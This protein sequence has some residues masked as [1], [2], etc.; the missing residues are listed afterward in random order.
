[1]PTNSTVMQMFI[2]A[3]IACRI[4]KSF[5]QTTQTLIGSL[6]QVLFDDGEHRVCIPKILRLAFHMKFSSQSF[7]LPRTIQ[8]HLGHAGHSGSC[9]FHFCTNLIAAS[10]SAN[11]SGVNM[12]VLPQNGHASVLSGKGLSIGHLK[13]FFPC[14]TFQGRPGLAAYFSVS[15]AQHVIPVRGHRYHGD[16]GKGLIGLDKLA[17][18]VSHVRCLHAHIVD[19]SLTDVKSYF[20]ELSI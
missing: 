9:A 10:W 11:S 2:F 19:Y 20:R 15:K 6:W 13:P 12:P 1:M 14:I 3:G 17:R 4:P 7:S 5:S 16:A 8:P 18:F